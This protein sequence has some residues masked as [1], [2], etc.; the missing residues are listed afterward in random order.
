LLLEKLKS[1]SEQELKVI[2]CIG[3]SLK[4]KEE[5]Q[6]VEALKRQLQIVKKVELNEFMIAYE[7]V[8]AI[9]SGITGDIDYIDKIHREIINEVSSYQKEGF[10]GVSY[11]GSVDSSNSK[12]ILSIKAVQGL[13]IGGASLQYQEFCNI[14]LSNN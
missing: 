13:L 7:P 10:L 9:G 3:E 2:F 6:T 1:A 11:G 5:N 12:D 8:W 14:V 4:E